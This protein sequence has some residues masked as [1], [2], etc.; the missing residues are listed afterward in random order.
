MKTF[1]LTIFGLYILANAY[2]GYSLWQIIPANLI[3]RITMLALLAVGFV[4][5]IIFFAFGESLDISTAGFLYKVGTSWMIAFLYLFI[6]ILL[7]DIFKLS[8]HIIGYVS[9]DTIHEIFSHNGITSIIIFG[10]TS[11]LLIAGNINY[12]NKKRVHLPIIS[13]KIDKPMRIVAVSDLHLGYTIGKKE[14][15]KW[16]TLINDE[17]P[18]MVLIA[19]DLIDNQL[20]PV[21]YQSMHEELQKIYAPLGI[22]ACTGNHEFISGIKESANFYKSAKIHLLR[23]SHLEV[24][25]I[26]IVSRDDHSRHNRTEL[27]EIVKDIDNSRFTILLDHQPSNI[28]AAVKSGIDLQLS[29]HTHHGQIFPVSLV[30]KKLFEVSHGYKQKGNTQIYVSSGLGIWGGKFRIGTQSEYVVID[31][32]NE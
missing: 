28:D 15:A 4:A 31:L 14:L 26:N 9:K 7:I 6:F 19:G 11:L 21:L 29:G 20:R 10:F 23:D 17:K 16:V 24:N 1:F 18:D 2:V 25:S 27:A 32:T 8:A 13:N 30:T 5:P 22:Y 12:H 3:V